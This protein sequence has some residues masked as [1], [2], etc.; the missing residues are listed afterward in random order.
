MRVAQLNFHRDAAGRAPA[1]LLAA[2]PT[3]GQLARSAA[4]GGAQVRVLQ[5]S[6]HRAILA[7]AGVEYRFGPLNGTRLQAAIADAE[8]L[9]V[10]GLGFGR[11]LRDLAAISAGRPIVLQDHA[12]RPPRLWRRWHWR[13][14]ARAA[15]GV[16]FCSREQA[17]PFTQRRL[18]APQTRIYELPESTSAFQ[19]QPREE[20]RR[21]T[22]LHGAPALLWVAHLDANKD[23]LTMLDALALA[24]PRLPDAQLWCCY[25]S[26]PLL[27]AVQQR[28]A[29][30]P[31]LAGR[32]HLQG[33]QQHERIETLMSAADLLVQAS[34]RESTGYSL[35]E[36]LACGLPP[37]VTGI[38]SF[39]AV[40][41]EGKD[42][43]GLSPVA[44]APALAT[45]LVAAWDRPQPALRAAARARFDEALSP[46]ALGR[47]LIEVYR[48]L[49]S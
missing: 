37:V 36:A 46:S 1:E 17:L 2:W 4:L 5:A 39:R 31:R 43:P 22:G 23:P 19:P 32:V 10:H 14:S 28:V 41:G 24:A 29:G 26:A 20:A 48:D 3:L 9:H 33:R 16:I 49:L 35:I 30:D 7:D 8:V 13:R 38:P 45:A 11:E 47:R 27:D 34:H 18:L 6:G 15:R 44:D 12:D 21:A 42:L 25:G 40:L